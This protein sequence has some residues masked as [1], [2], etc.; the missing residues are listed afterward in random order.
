VGLLIVITCFAMLAS[1]VGIW[2]R[3]S[4]L[5]NDVFD[6]RVAPLGADPRVQ[7]ALATFITNEVMITIDPETIFREA[8]PDQAQILSVPLA[9]AVEG[10]VQDQVENFL[11]T[12]QFAS[13]WASATT[14]AHAAAVNLVEGKSD[15]VG[16]DGDTLV[17]NLIPVINGVLAQIGDLSPDIFGRSVDLPTLTVDD[18]PTEAIDQLESALGIALPDDFGVIRVADAGGPLAAAQDG[19]RLFN[20]AVI[21]FVVV[22]LVCL[23]L[24]LWLSRR[25]RRTILQLVGGLA[26]TLM[27]FRRI[28]WRLEDDALALINDDTNREAADAVLSVFV[29]PLFDAITTILWVLFIVGVIA[30]VTGPY[31]WAVQLRRS[32]RQLASTA[33]DAAGSVHERAGRADTVEW[34]QRNLSALQAAGGGVAFILLVFF[35]LSWWSLFFLLLVLGGYEL[36]L[37]RIGQRVAGDPAEPAESAIDPVDP[38]RPASNSGATA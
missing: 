14:R 19:V 20:Y 11:A 31:V 5:N 10:F 28:G 24:A 36:V 37:W 3:R 35:N 2:A 13:L 17:I 34:V 38:E 16:T 33:M 8:L 12:D 26:I 21:G 15:V 29:N 6:D 32:A 30:L 23:A 4:A 7:A 18:I 27:L 9:S 22:A 1:V 25:R